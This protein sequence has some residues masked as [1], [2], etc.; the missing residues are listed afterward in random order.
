ML[1]YK[2]QRQ[3]WFSFHNGVGQ[4]PLVDHFR[5]R[6]RARTQRFSALLQWSS[7]DPCMSDFLSRHDA[8]ICSNAGFMGLW[9]ADTS[10]C[11]LVRCTHERTQALLGNTKVCCLCSQQR[12]LL[13]QWQF[14]AVL[15][16]VCL[17]KENYF[18]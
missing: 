6:R 17:S 2:R 16:N 3:G 9:V 1:L 13:C 15:N 10:T 12:M 5:E 8:F 14:I 7:P 4:M 18:C 11:A